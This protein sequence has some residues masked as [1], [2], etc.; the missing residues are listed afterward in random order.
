M[1]YS[2][3]FAFPLYCSRSE[4]FSESKLGKSNV[5]PS[6]CFA[7]FAMDVHGVMAALVLTY[8]LRSCFEFL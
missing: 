5:S 6:L 2:L 3:Q 8:S 7:V 4:S 1:A